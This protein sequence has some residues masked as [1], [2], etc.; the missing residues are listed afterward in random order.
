[1]D[2]NVKMHDCMADIDTNKEEACRYFKMA[3]DKGHL[4]AMNSYAFMLFNGLGIEQNQQEACR[5]FKMASDNG[6]VE[7]MFNYANIPDSGQGTEMNKK[8]A[9]QVK[10][11]GIR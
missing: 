9:A 8:E 3:A 7:G 5:Y 10:T 6:N 1:M 2:S 11:K 4:S